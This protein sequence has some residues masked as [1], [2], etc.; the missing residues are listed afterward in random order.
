MGTIIAESV[1]LLQNRYRYCRI[2]TV[3]AE[4]VPVLQNQ[5]RYFSGWQLLRLARTA[6]CE[7]VPGPGFHLCALRCPF[8]VYI[9]R[10]PMR[11]LLGSGLR[12]SSGA[13]PP[14]SRSTRPL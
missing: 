1:P 14:S 7:N 2:G 12:R 5:Y 8:S 3:V 9:A 6:V 4:S 11:L 10:R 13:W